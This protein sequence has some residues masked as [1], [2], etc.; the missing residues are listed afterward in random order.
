MMQTQPGGPSKD[1][2]VHRRAPMA[3][4]QANSGLR[5]FLQRKQG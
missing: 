1:L 2:K 3:S 4:G 5:L